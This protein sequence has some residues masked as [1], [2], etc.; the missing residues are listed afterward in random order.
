MR[1]CKYTCFQKFK[2]RIIYAFIFPIPNVLGVSVF[3]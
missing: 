1:V 3:N 2:K